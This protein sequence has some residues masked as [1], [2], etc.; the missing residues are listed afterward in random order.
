MHKGFWNA[1]AIRL[2]AGVF[3]HTTFC[4]RYSYFQISVSCLIADRPAVSPV[5]LADYFV[6][7]ERYSMHTSGQGMLTPLRPEYYIIGL[8][9]VQ[10]VILMHN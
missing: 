7:K 8:A 5:E 3:N 9:K 6:R 2:K 10:T 4:Q 1:L